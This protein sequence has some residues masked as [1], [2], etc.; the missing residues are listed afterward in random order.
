MASEALSLNIR[1][2]ITSSS[3]SNTCG[4]ASLPLPPAGP[5]SQ[6]ER[7]GLQGFPTEHSLAE[8]QGLGQSAE[9]D[10]AVLQF[11][12]LSPEQ[13]REALLRIERAFS[14]TS[15]HLS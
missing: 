3:T 10:A 4:A 11:S 12:R 8:G 15:G 5:S 7:E 13:R 14:A 9:V 2:S 1:S 6:Q